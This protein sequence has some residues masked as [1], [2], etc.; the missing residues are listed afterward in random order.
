[1]RKTI[2][3]L[4]FALLAGCATAATT[5]AK[6]GDQNGLRAAIAER[7]KA[8]AI[9]DAEAVEI[10]RLVAT[11]EIEGANPKDATDRVRDVRGCA[12]EL[13]DAL[14]TRMKTHDEAGAEAAQA[15]M[16]V[17]AFSASDAREFVND[18]SD[19][20]RAVG[21]RGLVRSEDKAA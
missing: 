5:A 3:M 18:P 6:R 11:H 9:D 13:E 14:E 4:A 21:A 10:A 12:K 1:M 20:W 17:T 7:H 16:D 19:A 2:G 8:G 15:L